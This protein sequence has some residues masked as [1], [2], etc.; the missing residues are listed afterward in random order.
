MLSYVPRAEYDAKAN[1]GEEATF[2]KADAQGV[3]E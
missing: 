3:Q 1:N 2:V